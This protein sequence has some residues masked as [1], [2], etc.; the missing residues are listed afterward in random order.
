MASPNDYTD[1]R[2]ALFTSPGVDITEKIGKQTMIGCK[3]GV[4]QSKFACN[5]ISTKLST[6]FTIMH[7]YEGLDGGG[8]GIHY[9]LKIEPII[10]LIKILGYSLK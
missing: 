4:Q 9:S 6:Q 10:H 1:V 3:Y 8:S 5:I 7:I 2:K